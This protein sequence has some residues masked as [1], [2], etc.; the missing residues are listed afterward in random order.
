MYLIRIH[1]PS[2]CA[3]CW[4]PRLLTAHYALPTVARWL[5]HRRRPPTQPTATCKVCA[6]QIVVALA[7]R[8]WVVGSL[9]RWV[10]GLL[11]RW[12]VGS[13]GRCVVGLLCRC[14][15]GSVIR[16]FVGSLDPWV[17]VRRRVD[18]M[19]RT[20]V[21]VCSGGWVVGRRGCL[22]SACEWQSW[23]KLKGPFPR[24]GFTS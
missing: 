6:N 23:R 1:R 24:V 16:W 20:A 22:W 18:T 5:A 10:V 3:G 4:L 9:G 21:V 19:F 13:L 12:F 17:L 15:V 7:L 8:R 2:R 14:V 11:C